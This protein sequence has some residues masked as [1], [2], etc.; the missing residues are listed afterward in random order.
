M[1][2]AIFSTTNL[3]LIPEKKYIFSRLQLIL[4]SSKGSIALF[5]IDNIIELIWNMLI[6]L[7]QQNRVKYIID[8][9]N[10]K[11]LGLY[12]RNNQ[13]AKLNSVDFNEI[14]TI[15]VVPKK[16]NYNIVNAVKNAIINIPKDIKVSGIFSYYTDIEYIDFIHY[17]EKSV[18]KSKD[19]FVEFN[20]EEFVLNKNDTKVIAWYLP[21][22][23][24]LEVNNKFHGQGFTEWTNT[25]RATPLFVGHYQ[26]HIPYDVG[27]YDLMNPEA[28]KRQI[29]LAKHYGIYGFCFHYYWFSGQKLMEKPLE[30]LKAHPEWDIPFCINWANE[31]W[32]SLWDGGN[33]EIMYE[34]KLADDDDE[35]FMID[36]I[37]YLKDK[38]YI[39]VSGKP[40]LSIYRHQLF[41]K[42]RYF[43]LLANFRKIA[44]DYGFPDLFIMMVNHSD[45]DE[46]VNDWGA[47]A[48]VEFQP[49]M[50]NKYLPVVKPTGY[51]NPYL[52]GDIFDTTDYI[53]NKKYLQKH[54]SKNVIR[55]ALTSYD[56]SARKCTTYC[57]IYPKLTPLTYKI[58][59]KDIILESKISH[60]NETDMDMV[61]VNAWNE[62]AEGQHLE[63]DCYYGYAYLQATREAV[64]ETR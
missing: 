14:D 64:E 38:R 45:F 46:N 40:I 24:Q 7:H 23:H 56:N 34:Q 57:W 20:P 1:S 43:Q 55:S 28:M 27:Y 59:L 11:F 22:F 33:R 8:F 50:M 19:N 18:L 49:F 4:N 51:L 16:D 29:Y 48:L 30:M 3:D 61:F 6:H 62:W 36:I 53:K 63:P 32:T 39:K 12:Y 58:W 17:N 35:K 44:K 54:N 13:I 15:I 52:F 26:P 2:E 9:D 25:S 5:G 31:N 60:K 42:K 37:P 21:Q 41:P 10:S 47:D